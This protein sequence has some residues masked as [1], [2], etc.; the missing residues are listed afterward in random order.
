MKRWLFAT[1]LFALSTSFPARADDTAKEKPVTVP[2][3]LLKTGHMTVMVK[4]NGKGPYRLIFDTGAPVTLLNTKIGVEAGLIKKG[5][6]KSLINP[7]NT[8]GP[9]K[10]DKL[11]VGD[12]ATE[13]VA[14]VV[15]DHPTLEVIS[16]RLG[17]I[18]GIVGLPFF[19]RFKM[20]MDY[21]K[22]EL[23]FTPNGYEPADALEAMKALAMGL[24]FR[25]KPPTK[26]LT[27]ASQWGL[28]VDK[29][30]DDEEDGVSIKKVMPGSAADKAG[31]KAD[32]RLLILDDRWTDSVA[33][34]YAAA[35]SV[36]PGMTVKLKIKR[37]GKTRELS[38]APT[39]GL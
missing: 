34:C 36:K 23:T 39:P 9:T 22:K 30:E 7:Y 4:V 3:E 33:D 37:G 1:A 31:L 29:S 14:A 2:F 16:K 32:D 19:G 28:V 26:V 38:I 18:D 21:Q 20:T 10:V 25:E 17:A 12:L 24:L 13:K 6:K 11:E 27:T 5:Q 35:A 15:M 8:A